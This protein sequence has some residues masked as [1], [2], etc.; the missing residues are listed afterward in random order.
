MQL[1][2]VYGPSSKVDS[3]FPF[4]RDLKV[5]VNSLSSLGYTT[6]TS[7]LLRASVEKL[8]ARYIS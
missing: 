2:L 5:L 3:S 1:G 7:N 6:H 8:V 4:D